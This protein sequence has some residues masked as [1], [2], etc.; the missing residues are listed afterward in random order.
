MTNAKKIASGFT[1]IALGLPA[2]AMALSATP[3]NAA[4]VTSTIETYDVCSWE[5]SGLD[6]KLDLV[7]I[8]PSTKGALP[9][10]T[11]YV[12]QKMQLGGIFDITMALTGKDA[13]G[14]GISGTSTQCSFYGAK[15]YPSV[16]AALATGDGKT[17]RFTARY[18][19]DGEVR[20]DSRLSVQLGPG[21]GDGFGPV[22][23]W[24]SNWSPGL[25]A[26]ED[27][28]D[29]PVVDPLKFGAAMLGL[30]SEERQCI[31]SSVGVADSIMRG[32]D[33]AHTSTNKMILWTT[34][35]DAKYEAGGTAPRC[36]TRT[37]LEFYI[38]NISQAPDAAGRQFTLSGPEVVYSL[39]TVDT[40]PATPVDVGSSIYGG[41]TLAGLIPYLP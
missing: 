23:L 9:A 14:T 32:Y 27:A 37:L 29:D 12:G 19:V 7:P 31:R 39:S 33:P 6:G 41:A 30:S 13:P 40:A 10:G 4:E 11:K 38:P 24:A 25:G 21:R 16:S 28:L 22:P 18:T 5:L 35:V 3:A 34:A 17:D 2:M 15:K 26:V 1:L 20:E 8:N 36:K